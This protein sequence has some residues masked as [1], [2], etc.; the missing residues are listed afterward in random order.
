MT[1]EFC[2]FPECTD[3]NTDYEAFRRCAKCSI[4]SPNYAEVLRIYRKYSVGPEPLWQVF[5]RVGRELEAIF[6]SNRRERCPTCGHTDLV[7]GRLV[8]RSCANPWHGDAH[9]RRIPADSKETP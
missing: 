5:V 1:R 7:F 9:L 2:K 8:D 4:R 3:G 6:A